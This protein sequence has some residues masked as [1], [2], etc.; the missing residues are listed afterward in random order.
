MSAIVRSRTD[1]RSDR[2]ARRSQAA[3]VT[4]FN[5]LILER[6]YAELTPGTV[7]EAADIGR[8]TFYEHFSGLDDLLAQTLGPVFAPLANGCFESTTS[9]AAFKTV[10]HLWAN[11]RL[12]RALMCGDAYAVVLRSFAA[13]FTSAV[14]NYTGGRSIQ[15]EPELIGLQLAAGQL[16]VLSAWLSGRSNHSACEIAYALHAS[17]RALLIA[18]LETSPTSQ[19]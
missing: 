19:S 6:G 2:R 10:E 3:I 9:D 18:M 11:R 4:A 13:R 1:G 7:A 17:G 12:A 15:L 14:A 16:A 5:R 8:S